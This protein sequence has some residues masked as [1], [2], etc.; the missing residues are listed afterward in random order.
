[1][2]ER[3]GLAVEGFTVRPV[4]LF[5]SCRSSSED[6]L[7]ANEW[8]NCK[9]EHKFFNIDC[10]FSRDGERKVYVQDRLRKRDGEVGRGT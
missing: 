1:M 4:L 3:A 5:L 6:F 10:A 9:R 2:Q 8:E 7:Y